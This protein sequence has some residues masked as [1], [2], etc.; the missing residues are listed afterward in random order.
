M[1]FPAMTD[2]AARALAGVA[3]RAAAP[4]PARRGRRWV[5]LAVGVVVAAVAA[6]MLWGREPTPRQ[7]AASPGAESGEAPGSEP[8]I[9]DPGPEPTPDQPR[10]AALTPVASDSPPADPAATDSPTAD[11]R[12]SDRR[13]AA[14]EQRRPK[15]QGTLHVG[16]NPWADVF[17]DGALV[18]QAPGA[19]PVAAGPHAVELR[20]RER[21]RTFKVNVDPGETERLG[22]VDFT[23]P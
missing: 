19:F 4:V 3:S 21:R 22:L 2:S 8:G 6:A 15:G 5:A 14:V 20:Y 17:V 10:A 18:G 9:A 1:P 12:P 13:S 11:P 23:A 16:A 7:V